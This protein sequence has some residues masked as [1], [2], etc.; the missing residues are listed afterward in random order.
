M[1]LITVQPRSF[2]EEKLLEKILANNPSLHAFTLND[3]RR[4]RDKTSVYLFV[5]NDNVL[6]YLLA[7]AG[8]GRY[9]SIIV[10]VFSDTVEPRTIVRQLLSNSI[11]LRR[12]FTGTVHVDR[13]LLDV[14]LGLL[15]PSSIYYYYVMEYTGKAPECPR[16]SY[17]I[18]EL[19]YELLGKYRASY[20]I[21]RRV[22]GLKK[23]YGVVVNN[24]IVGVGGYYVVEPEVYLI[25]GIYVEP[26]YR[27]RGIGKY[28][29]CFLT[30]KALED[31]DRVVLWVNTENKPAI[32]I[33]DSIGYRVIRVNAWVNININVKP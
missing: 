3:L 28:I 22:K 1:P 8:L 32:R 26:E 25:G 15:R 2:Y 29:S 10:E 19:E 23:T 18:I 6:G 30:R 21:A 27:G 16:S 24:R 5:S 4:E 17:D 11:V 9:Y 14:V 7:Y 13:R 33:Y 12:D 31:T 20:E